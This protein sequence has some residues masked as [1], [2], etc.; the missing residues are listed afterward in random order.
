[1]FEVQSVVN[2]PVSPGVKKYVI[3]GKV[4]GQSLSSFGG[5]D[6]EMRRKRREV[7]KTR[8]G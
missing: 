5:G 4:R 7:E 2:N 6:Q 8:K 3:I 1:M